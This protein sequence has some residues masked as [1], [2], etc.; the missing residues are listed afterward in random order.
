ML[1]ERK[2]AAQPR[3]RSAAKNKEVNIFFKKGKGGRDGNLFLLLF[4]LVFALRRNKTK[5]PH[6][7]NL[8][9]K[10]EREQNT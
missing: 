8:G 1:H 6:T 9:G 5:V 3:R 10:P 4:K 2:L 7:K